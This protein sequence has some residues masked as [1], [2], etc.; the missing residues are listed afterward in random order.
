MRYIYLGDRLTDSALNGMQC[1]PVRDAR[2][3]CVCGRGSMLVQDVHG[4]RYVVIRRRL[5]LVK[6]DS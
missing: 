2:G 6:G 1:D 3:K 5:R 4:I